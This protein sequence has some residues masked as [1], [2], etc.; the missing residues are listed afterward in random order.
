M[1]EGYAPAND[2]HGKVDDLLAR[3]KQLM[4]KDIEKEAEEMERSMEPAIDFGKYEQARDI[5]EQVLELDPDNQDALQ[6]ISDCSTM[7]EPYHPVQYMAPIGDMP[8]NISM[9]DMIL[10][11]SGERS[12]MSRQ[13]L[14]WEIMRARRGR[15]KEGIAYTARAFNEAG[16]EAS[17]DVECILE[18]AR[19]RANAGECKESIFRDIKQELSDFQEGL[20]RGWKGHGP[21]VT[22]KSMQELKRVLGMERDE[23]S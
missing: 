21:D 22:T 16:R 5:F 11:P 19:A 15:N 12:G 2:I 13:G 6:G 9:E 4:L 10:A 18:K 7:L 23:N 3:A 17:H 1:N 8:V 14:P 20:D